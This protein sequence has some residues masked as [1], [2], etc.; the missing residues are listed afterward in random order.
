MEFYIMSFLNPIDLMRKATTCKFMNE[1]SKKSTIDGHIILHILKILYP[2]VHIDMTEIGNVV[3]SK[4]PPPLQHK[5]N[6]ETTDTVTT[7]HSHSEFNRIRPYLRHMFMYD[8]GTQLKE[9]GLFPH[10]ATACV[11]QQL[12]TMGIQDQ[13][14]N[15]FLNH[16]LSTGNSI[17]FRAKR[18]PFS[19]IDILTAWSCY[20]LLSLKRAAKDVCTELQPAYSALIQRHND[21]VRI[22]RSKFSCPPVN[23]NI[24]YVRFSE[25]RLHRTNTNFVS[26]RFAVCNQCVLEV[27]EVRNMMKD[28]RNTSDLLWNARQR[29]KRL[30]RLLS[31]TQDE[32]FVWRKRTH[33]LLD[34]Q[35]P[36][37]SKVSDTQYIKDPK[38]PRKR[39]KL[40]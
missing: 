6:L 13:K 9:M 33:L 31:D 10:R 24:Y 27:Q 3:L 26:N 35:L 32:V 7:L 39:R 38:F 36:L 23:N 16:T 40:Q 4:V 29:N 28:L 11:L 2:N 22:V 30:T 1:C 5:F 17:Y 37:Q 20:H 8:V 12:A 25:G 19:S 34:Q 15:T 21:F 18:K 14:W